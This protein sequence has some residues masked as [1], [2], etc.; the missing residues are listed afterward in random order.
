MQL[1][2]EIEQTQS[3]VH[4]ERVRDDFPML[5][6]RVHGKPIVY[7]DNAASSLKPSA[8]VDRLERFY[9]TQFANT[10]ENNSL[11]QAVTEVVQGVRSSVAKLLMHTLG[12]PGA[13]RASFM[14]YNTQQEIDALVRSLQKIVH[15]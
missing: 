13:V 4:V 5:E 14:F 9:S 8:M 3:A 7:L 1:E 15:V 10:N 6:T 2:A 11:S 12:L